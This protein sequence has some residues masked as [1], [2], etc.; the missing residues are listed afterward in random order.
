MGVSV[1]QT[2]L[3]YLNNYL[4]LPFSYYGFYGHLY[5]AIFNLELILFGAI[6]DNN[7]IIF[8]IYIMSIVKIN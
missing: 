6:N 4:H 8:S 3:I 7:F 5:N 2:E 1:K